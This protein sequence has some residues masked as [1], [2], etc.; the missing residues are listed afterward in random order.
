MN[1]HMGCE[2]AYEVQKPTVFIMCLE[3]ARIA[4]HAGFHEKLTL[5]PGCARKTYLHA[6]TGNRMF[7]FV[8]PEGRMSLSYEASVD[9]HVVRQ[10]PAGISETPVAELP[11]EI[12]HYLFPSRYSP[13][14]RLASFAAREFGR[15][16]P[17]HGRVTAICNWIYDNLAYQPGSSATETSAVET[18]LARAGVC[19]DF[20]HLGV[21]FCRALGVPAR[22]VSCYAHGLEPADFH[23]VFEAWLGGHWWLFDATRQ[24]SLD[25]LVRIGVGRDAADVSFATIYGQVYPTGMTIWIR[26]ADGEVQPAERTTQ[27]VRTA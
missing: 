13:S 22:F 14:D 11:L 1:F 3:A 19:R 8:A 5:V 9:L 10:D 27:A 23:A 25:G 21:A 15:M 7:S 6:E 26:P 12:V 17:G 20:A 2:L 16:Q 24:A 18:L 4:S